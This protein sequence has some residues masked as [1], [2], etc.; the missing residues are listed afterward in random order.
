MSPTLRILRQARLQLRTTR[1]SPSSR[2]QTQIKYRSLSHT[3]CIY[4]RKNA[5]DREDIDPTPTEYSKSGS[6]SGAAAQDNA[7]FD[8]GE[9]S[10]EGSK[11]KAGEGTEG[12]SLEFSPANT[13]LSKQPDPKGDKSGAENSGKD[14]EGN[15]GSQSGGGRGNV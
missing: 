6:D 5:Q 4:A 10:P 11:R 13:D 7:A 3:P 12:N 8:R 1:I 14:G 9:S 2:C 15:R